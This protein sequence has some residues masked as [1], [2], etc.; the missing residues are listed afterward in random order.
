[1]F[2]KSYM[3]R[4]CLYQEKHFLGLLS[5]F[6]GYFIFKKKTSIHHLGKFLNASYSLSD[7]KTDKGILYLSN[8]FFFDS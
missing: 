2:K 6:A 3:F 1:M 4:I 8:S 5:N 7:T